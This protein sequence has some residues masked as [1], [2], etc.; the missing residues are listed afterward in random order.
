MTNNTTIKF[1]H[2][3]NLP[4]PIKPRRAV[5][6]SAPPRRVFFV[7]RVPDVTLV[8]MITLNNTD[9]FIIGYCLYSI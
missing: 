7:G 4:A 3:A 5:F 9:S 6:A 2:V 1:C 8:T